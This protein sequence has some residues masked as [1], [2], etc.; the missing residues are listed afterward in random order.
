MA[1][2]QPV[3]LSPAQGPD[4]RFQGTARLIA[5]SPGTDHREFTPRFATA[6]AVIASTLQRDLGDA[7]WWRFID[8]LALIVTFKQRQTSPPNPA[9]F[10]AQRSAGYALE[11]SLLRRVVPARSRRYPRAQ[12]IPAC[13]NPQRRA[14]R[15]RSAARSAIATTGAWVPQP[16]M[17]GI[18][19][20]SATRSPL[21]PA[22][23]RSGSTTLPIAAV[24]HG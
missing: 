2:G 15:I 7:D 21:T 4:V 17:T 22:T 24:P 11:S 3:A 14:W 20:A 1:V 10:P 18:T 12:R 23:L 8:A 6:L 13:Q 9:G 5:D 19:D 16:G